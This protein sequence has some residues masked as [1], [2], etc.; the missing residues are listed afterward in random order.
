LSARPVQVTFLGAGSSGTSVD[1]GRHPR[2]AYRG[3]RRVAAES[4]IHA[5]A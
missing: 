2:E 3:L 5:V 4:E 1:E